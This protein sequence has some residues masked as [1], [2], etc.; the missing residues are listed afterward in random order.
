M[1]DML[2]LDSSNVL[3]LSS[4]GFRIAPFLMINLFCVGGMS[5]PILFGTQETGGGLVT[6]SSR[7]NLK[8]FVKQCSVNFILTLMNWSARYLSLGDGLSGIFFN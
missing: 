2:C 8:Y 6:S 7:K 1:L 4:L 3:L 5:A